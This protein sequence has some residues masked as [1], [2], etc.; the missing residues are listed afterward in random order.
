MSLNYQPFAEDPTFVALADEVVAEQSR[1]INDFERVASCVGGAALFAYGVS[2]RTLPGL[3]IGLIGGAFVYRGA[4]GNCSVYD[5]LNINTRGK[6]RGRGV[7]DNK[8][9][10]VEERIIINRPREEIYAFWRK[11]ENLPA[12]M[13]HLESVTVR[14]ERHSHWVAKAPVGQT[15]SWDAEIINDHAP[16]M[17]A[18]QSLP[19]ADVQNAGSVW[20]E[21][22]DGGTEVKVVLEYNPP[23]GVLGA[24]VA[25]IFGE[26]P[27]V[28]VREDLQ[29]LKERLEGTSAGV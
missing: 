17:I 2:Q 16:T 25:R 10:K 28:Q 29:R 3:L 6:E 12:F 26:A 8:G 5:S 14:D 1:N 9:V 27:G 24:A 22:A 15:V 21:P 7:P 4:T 18:W 19:G 11:L 23:G 20:F 13:K